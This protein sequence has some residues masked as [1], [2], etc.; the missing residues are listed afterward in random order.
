M[1]NNDGKTAYELAFNKEIKQI[2]DLFLAEKNL[3]NSK[4][5]QKVHIHTIKSEQV[6]QMFDSF[7][8]DPEPKDQQLISDNSSTSNTSNQIS[9]VQK[10]LH[11]NNKSITPIKKIEL[12]IDTK[13]F[14]I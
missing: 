13:V 6:Q 4:F 5:S 1:K 8:P 7:K 14:I 12:E 3:L 2:F 11:N 10:G 9:T